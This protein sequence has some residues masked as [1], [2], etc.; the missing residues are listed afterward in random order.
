MTGVQ[1]C[2]LPIFTGLA[3]GLGAQEYIK[4]NPTAE[5]V[6]SVFKVGESFEIAHNFTL[7]EM[8]GDT[9]QD[10]ILRSAIKVELGENSELAEARALVQSLTFGGTEEG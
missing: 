5:T 8:V 10:N 3:T 1:T 9:Q 6:S 7:S 2:A 4:N